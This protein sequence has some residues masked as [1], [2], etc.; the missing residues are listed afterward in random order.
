MELPSLIDMVSIAT[1]AGLAL[2]QA[3]KLVTQE[4]SGMVALELQRASRE[5][6]LGQRTL[7]EALAS[8]AERN[9]IPELTSFVGQ[10]RASHEQGIPLAQALAVQAETL[11]EQKRLKIV[12]EGG[13]ASVRMIL[14]V[15]L[16]IFPVMFVVLLVPAGVQ[17]LRIT[18]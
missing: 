1:S 10:L 18:G 16:F 8:M 13:K 17:L 11:R 6:E 4:S 5:A 7:V 15:A 12:E 2:E 3:I 9:A 14:P